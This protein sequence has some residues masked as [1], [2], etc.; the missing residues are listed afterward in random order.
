MFRQ[1]MESYDRITRIPFQNRMQVPELDF[2]DYENHPSHLH[3]S[4]KLLADGM[5]HFPNS[6]DLVTFR[7]RAQNVKVE[8]GDEEANAE[9]MTTMKFFVEEFST[10]RRAEDVTVTFSL[11][12]FKQFLSAWDKKTQDIYSYFTERN[13]VVFVTECFG[14]TT[15]FMVASV[16]KDHT[17]NSPV[18]TGHETMSSIN[19]T[20]NT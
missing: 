6:I 17:P 20:Y 19:I 4:V 12:L 7:I 11:K 16:L 9:F 5:R 10:Y 3:C 2:G 18:P 1:K 13:G 14:F 8:T 15:R